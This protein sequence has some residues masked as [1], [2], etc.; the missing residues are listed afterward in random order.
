MFLKSGRTAIME[1]N[2]RS[3][4]ENYA[5]TIILV[6]SILAGSIVGFFLKEKAVVLKPLGDIFLNLLFTLVVPLV[7]FSISSA[8]AGMKDL[9]RLGKIMLWMMVIFI[10]AG[11][12]SSVFMVLGVKIYPPA[13]GV[14]INLDHQFIPGNVK[15]SEQIVRAFTVSE[16]S[17]L[18]TKK[19][20]L[21]LILISLLVGLGAGSAG[22]KARPL[23]Q[24]LLAGNE[25]MKKV[26]SFIMYYAPVGL[27]AYFAF[28]VGTFGPAMLG[29][30]FRVIVLY[31]PLAIIYFVVG[32]SLYAY[33]AGNFYGV[34]KFWS[35]IVPTAITAWGT[36][37]SVAAI[38][39]NLEA[40]ERIGVPEDIREVVVPMGAM[41][42]KSGSCLAA[43]LKIAFLFGI[44]NM[45]FSGA[46]TI[47]TAVIVAILSGTVMGGIPGGG[48]LGEI[49]IVTL[50]GFPI[51]SLP[52]ISMIGT[53]VDP[54]ATMV[55]SVGDNVASMLVSRILGGKN[56]MPRE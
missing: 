27:G 11:V 42:H 40:A 20:M 35:N 48:F 17:E 18:L 30:Y 50:Y 32:F 29:A 22:E 56:W 46:G 39:A 44:F 28:L 1:K 21:A 41:I 31:Y 24:V 10:L 13:Q 37:S 4:L 8:V 25:A 33:L 9:E 15:V 45:S 36:G 43:I 38:P 34:K 47:T 16:F 55:N 53:L 6:M 49:M 54:P 26:I 19:S 3:F 14:T 12:V 51:E 52:L 2:N 5:F 7:F 23:V